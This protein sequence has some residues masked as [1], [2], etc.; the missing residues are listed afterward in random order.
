MAKGGVCNALDQLLDIFTVVVNL[1][2]F[3]SL[4]RYS[5]SL[6]IFYLTDGHLKFN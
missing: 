5:T 2:S 1:F 4:I 6:D 3:S